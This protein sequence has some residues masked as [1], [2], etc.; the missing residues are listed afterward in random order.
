MSPVNK[1]RNI[2]A[3]LLDT[4]GRLFAQRG[5]SGTSVRDIIREAGATLSAVNYYFETKENLY[6]E[7]IRYVL[8]EKIRMEDI[9]HDFLQ[10]N[11]QTHQEISD[12]L[13]L[14]IQKT[15]WKFIDPEEPNW[16]VNFF[17]RAMLES[18]PE[19]IQVFM[20][21]GNT[22]IKKFEYRLRELLPDME[23][24]AE[25]I[26]TTNMFGQIHFYTLAKDLILQSKNIADYTPSFVNRVSRQIAR[27]LILPLGLPE[28]NIE[29]AV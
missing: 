11:F 17:A 2:K 6:L 5:F 20:E 22:P 25:A 3:D 19:S 29:T 18:T 24:M 21:Y 14:L 23:E 16:Y 7:T 28:P 12:Q 26:F 13:F 1:E 15:T 9:F 10:V 27:N 8:T 4:A